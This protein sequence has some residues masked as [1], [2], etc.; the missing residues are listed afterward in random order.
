MTTTIISSP[1]SA[2][3]VLGGGVRSELGGVSPS[4]PPNPRAPLLAKPSSSLGR[5]DVSYEDEDVSYVGR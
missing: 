3:A 4:S 5:D 2:A 1:S